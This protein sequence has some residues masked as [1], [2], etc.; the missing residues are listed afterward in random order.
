MSRGEAM[1]ALPIVRMG[2]HNWSGD[3]HEVGIGTFSLLPGSDWYDFGGVA[4]Q[5][6]PCGNC[7]G[8]GGG[9]HRGEY[10]PGS[11]VQ[12]LWEDRPKCHGLGVIPRHGSIERVEGDGPFN[13]IA[14]PV[15]VVLVVPIKGDE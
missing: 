7:G 1:K 9:L 2:K 10:P 11:G 3:P 8:K 15:G 14:A 13:I 12:E 4:I 5:A 6:D